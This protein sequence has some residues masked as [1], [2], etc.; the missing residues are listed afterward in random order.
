M[1][2]LPVAALGASASASTPDAT[3]SPSSPSPSPFTDVPK[4][5]WD[6]GAIDFVAGTHNW[7]QDYGASKFRPTTV[8][9]R[10]QLARALVRA[11]AP[12]E[13]VDPTITFSDLPSSDPFYPFANVAVKLG[14]MTRPAGSFEPTDP[15]NIAM[16]QRAL[17]LAMGMKDAVTGLDGVHLPDGTP[18]PHPPGFAYNDIAMLVGLRTNHPSNVAMAVNPTDPAKRSEVA[19]SLMHAYSAVRQQS[20]TISWVNSMFANGVQLPQLSSQ[21]LPI[22]EFGFKYVG[23]P[24]IW[25]GEWGS[26]TPSSYCCGY[27]PVGGFDCSGLAWWLMKAPDTTINWNNTS[28]RPYK[29]WPLAARTADGMAA[30][31]K[32]LT[33]DQ[34]RPGDLM[35][36]STATPPNSTIG[37]VDVYLG[38]GWALDSSGDGVTLM[39]ISSGWYRTHFQWARDIIG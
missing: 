29:G 28:I 27:Q 33:W 4:T 2:L 39:K 19:Y 38:N 32:K 3:V 17:V 22:A 15:V 35:F 8:E 6:Y 13:P 16:L 12:T 18:V 36:Y 5:Y 9:T 34:A 21:V 7:M 31:G 1:A 14:W 23:Y 11:F 30:V 25:G 37:H 20:W 24:Y 10:E 26:K